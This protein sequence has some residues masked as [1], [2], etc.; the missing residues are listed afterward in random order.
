MKFSS[1][2]HSG[3]CRTYAHRS[4]FGA[5]RGAH[6]VYRLGSTVGGVPALAS[7][8]SANAPTATRTT[9]RTTRVIVVVV[10]RAR[11]TT[12]STRAVE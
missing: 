6:D 4:A 2:A 1:R 3:F 10:F 8:S 12:P 9:T 7:E 5:S 11:M